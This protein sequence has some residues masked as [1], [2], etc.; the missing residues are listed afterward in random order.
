MCL[1]HALAEPRVPAP[2]DVPQP[3]AAGFVLRERGDRREPAL[4]AAWQDRLR[5]GEHRA[6][7]PLPQHQQEAAAGRSRRLLFDS[8]QLVANHANSLQIPKNA[9]EVN[10]RNPNDMSY[11]FSAAYSP[12]ICKLIEKVRTFS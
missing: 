10:I 12:L 5:S 6:L 3:E 1:L 11:V 4:E 8:F 2:V 7:E 9:E